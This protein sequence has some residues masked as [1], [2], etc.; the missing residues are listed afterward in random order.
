MKRGDIVLIKNRFDIVGWFIRRLL[1]IKYNHVGWAI[2]SKQIIEC[3]STGIYINHIKKYQNFCYKI[4]VLRIQDINKE[5]LDLALRYASVIQKKYEYL[6]SIKT[7]IR[8]LF[9]DPIH[10]F[11]CS[12]FIA[13]FLSEQGFYFNKNKHPL[14]I[15]PR[16][17]EKCKYL[18]EVNNE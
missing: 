17:I 6:S 10:R 5:K 9:N 14:Y 18:E 3:R 4:K 12:G 8:I 13:Y 16:D 7:Y 2:N 11:T 1:W 15:T